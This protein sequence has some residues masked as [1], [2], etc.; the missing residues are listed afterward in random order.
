LADTDQSDAYQLKDTEKES[1]KFF[2]TKNEQVESKTLE[3]PWTHFDFGREFGQ[4]DELFER[5]TSCF[6]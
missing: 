5:V 1:F 6:N 3:L 2:F 4:E